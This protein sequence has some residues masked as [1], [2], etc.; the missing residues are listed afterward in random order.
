MKTSADFTE[1]VHGVLARR[2]VGDLLASNAAVVLE[3]LARG[4]G[5]TEWYYCRGTAEL[6]ALEKRLSAGSVVSFYFDER[7]RKLPKSPQLAAD[8]ERII[9][10]TGD[11]VVG[12][13]GEDGVKIDVE[14][15][16]SR[17]DL[18]DFM[19]RLPSSS[20]VFYGAFPGRDDDGM[21]AVTVTLPDRDG[22][23]RS[24]PH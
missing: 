1:I 23:T 8:I 17:D 10:E 11:A 12:V 16:V 19:S 13:L 9:A 15:V 21:P 22:V 24:H 3:R 7:I 6:D 2:R 20:Q 5:A 14:I 18:A 4:G